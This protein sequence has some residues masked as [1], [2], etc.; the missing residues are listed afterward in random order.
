M[1]AI[2][3]CFLSDCTSLAKVPFE[4]PRMMADCHG[5]KGPGEIMVVANNFS[6][7]IGKHEMCY[8]GQ[9]AAFTNRLH[10]QSAILKQIAVLFNR[11]LR[12]S[13]SFKGKH[14]LRT[15]L[16]FEGA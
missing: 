11:L 14:S 2:S 8:M 5:L 9:K 6:I 15:A 10:L 7:S 3:T 16:L 12:C 4:C 1:C 13:S